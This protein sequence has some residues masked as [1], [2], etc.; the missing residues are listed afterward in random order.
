MCTFLYFDRDANK[1]ERKREVVSFLF[2]SLIYHVP[3]FVEALN[4]GR[5]HLTS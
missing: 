5:Q 4:L 1:V 2:L 3:F